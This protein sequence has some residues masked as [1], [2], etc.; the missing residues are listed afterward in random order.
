MSTSFMVAVIS[1]RRV[2]G[3]RERERTAAGSKLVSTRLL[4]RIEGGRELG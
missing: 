3:R 2:V 4:R 1:R